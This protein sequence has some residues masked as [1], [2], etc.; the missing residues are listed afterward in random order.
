MGVIINPRGTSGSGKTELVRRLLTSYGWRRGAE[1]DGA[2]DLKLIYRQGRSRPLGYRL[3]HPSGGPPLAVLGHYE[4]A[5]GGCDTIRAADGGLGEIMRRAADYAAT[6]HDVL[7][8][9]Q[10]LSSD[11]ESS[12][13]LARAHRL[14]IL[15]LTTPLEQCARNLVR[16][17]RARR[18][19]WPSVAGAVAIE[20]QA[21]AR[22]CDWLRQHA[23]I[24]ALGFDAALARARDLLR[25]CQR[26]TLLDRRAGESIRAAGGRAWR[27]PQGER[28]GRRLVAGDLEEELA[29]DCRGEV[30]VVLGDH[31]EGAR[32]ADH[33]LLVVAVE[34]GRRAAAPGVRALVDDR[35]AVD[36]DAV[37]DRLVSAPS[38]HRAATVVVAV[39]RDVDHPSQALDVVVAEKGCR[40]VDRGA[41]RGPV[42][43]HQRRLEQCI[44]EG[45]APAG[46]LDYGPLQH[47]ALVVV[48]RPFDIGQR[49][50][51]QHAVLL[52]ASTTSG[53][54][55]AAM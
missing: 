39:A 11:Y 35:Q 7:I 33:Q 31:D 32:A 52:I 17:R 49:D 50:A 5:S 42:R 29:E 24:E 51:A 8:E 23:T 6:G 38:W 28:A 30:G 9:G 43:G 46:I 34:V 12:A 16:R 41:E 18:S 19:T 14:H 13:V 55:S 45:V 26:E 4:V 2:R 21:V 15:R 37:G 25:L 1:F 36:G 10:L 54:R 20:H 47:R 40:V 44:G 27:L 48:A 3:R 53:W 22:A